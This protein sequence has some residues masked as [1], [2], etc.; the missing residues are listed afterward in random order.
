MELRVEDC[1]DAAFRKV[2]P[3]LRVEDQTEWRL[4]AGDTPEALYASGD[5]H[6]PVGAGTLTRMAVTQD[7]TP[8][9]VWGVSPAYP[10][11]ADSYYSKR[12]GWVWLVAT[13]EAV[14]VAR[15]IHRHLKAEFGK[16]REMYP[17]L[18]TASYIRNPEHHRWLKW[19]GFEQYGRK[20]ITPMGGVFLPFILK[21]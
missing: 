16:L 3:R 12:F 13:T 10:Q 6:L 2:S 15:S 5:Y 14:P 7:G 21:E 4:S 19:L 18:I 9:C 1:D 17:V 8:L 20:I 11:D